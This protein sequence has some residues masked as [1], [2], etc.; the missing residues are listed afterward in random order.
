MIANGAS[1]PRVVMAE[2]LLAVQRISRCPSW[3]AAG[4]RTSTTADR[5]CL[6]LVVIDFEPSLLMV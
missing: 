2:V 6:A 3:N 4:R 5:D 1:A